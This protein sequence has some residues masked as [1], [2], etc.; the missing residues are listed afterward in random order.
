MPYLL[1]FH[2]GFTDIFNCLALITYYFKK[3]PDEKMFLICRHEMKECILF[4][5][6]S[7]KNIEF[8]FESFNSIE[9]NFLKKYIQKYSLT[10][11]IHGNRDFL[12]NDNYNRVFSEKKYNFVKAFYECYDIPFDTR[13]KDFEIERDYEKEEEFYKKYR[14]ERENYICIHE[15]KGVELPKKPEESVSTKIILLAK[16]TECFFDS[17]KLLE[18][19]KEIHVID[20]VWMVFLYLLQKRYGLFSKIPI[21]AWCLR[22][23]FFM[24]NEP[25]LE[26]WIIH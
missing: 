2:Q 25:K 24:I 23:Y 6:R 5:T 26:N 9:E 19:A 20:S 10:P 16:T 7:Y 1:Y 3:Y 14:G 21:H 13:W 15:E 8:F 18:G 11:Y 17:I 4:Y 12:R 22:K